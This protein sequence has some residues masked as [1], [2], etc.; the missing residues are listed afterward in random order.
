MTT[1]HKK[2]RKEYCNECKKRFN[3]STIWNSKCGRCRKKLKQ[4]NKTKKEYNNKR[5][6]MKKEEIIKKIKNNEYSFE[7]E[8]IISIDRTNIILEIK[9][10]LDEE[11]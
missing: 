8:N 11:I 9:N 7:S 6:K 4:M 3:A 5:F 2:G 10:L 1:R